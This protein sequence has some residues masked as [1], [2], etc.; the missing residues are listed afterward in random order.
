MKE[1]LIALFIVSWCSGLVMFE[2][3]GFAD[4]QWWVLSKLLALR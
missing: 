4:P 1:I 3:T 2:V